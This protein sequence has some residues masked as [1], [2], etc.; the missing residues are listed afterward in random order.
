[1]G[2]RTFRVSTRCD[3]LWYCT[4]SCYKV[5]EKKV[6]VPWEGEEYCFYIETWE[7]CDGCAVG[8]T[9]GSR[10]CGEGHTWCVCAGDY[11]DEPPECYD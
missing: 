5:G 6:C 3:S 11:G 7:V 4:G 2:C 8:R 9:H 10:Y 1:M